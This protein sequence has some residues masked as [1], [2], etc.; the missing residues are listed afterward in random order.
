MTGI[1]KLNKAIEEKLQ[2][3][4]EKL[5]AQEILYNQK[6]QKEH[7]VIEKFNQK[8]AKHHDEAM[9]S[10]RVIWKWFTEFD[11]ASNQLYK[12]YGAYNFLRISEDINGEELLYGGVISETPMCFG[13]KGSQLY[14]HHCVKYGRSN[15]IQNE[16]D[17]VTYVPYRVLSKV[18]Q[19]IKNESIWDIIIENIEK[20]D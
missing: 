7:E 9:E 10:A 18:A 8:I 14:I 1:D 13:I 19:T 16:N 4:K 3:R 11:P 12:I 2:E 6:K 15:L 17:L 20:K 5:K